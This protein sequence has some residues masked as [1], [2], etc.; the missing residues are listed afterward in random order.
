MW[1]LTTEL[2]WDQY[3]EE[4]M[5]SP[6]SGKFSSLK[7][8]IP[9]GCENYLFW[10]KARSVHR[11]QNVHSFTIFIMASISM[12]TSYYIGCNSV[13]GTGHSLQAGW[14]RDGIPVGEI[15]TAPLETSNGAHPA[16]CTIGPRFL[17]VQS[18]HSI[19]HLPPLSAE[20]KERV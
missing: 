16:S 13:V 4:L 10:Y 8:I 18:G 19:D 11:F 1:T 3:M 7:Y 15:F 9:I 17:W 12:P 14:Y 5:F 20:V 2:Q 6:Y